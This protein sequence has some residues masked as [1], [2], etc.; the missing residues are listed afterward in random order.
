M[1]ILFAFGF[2]AI[3]A[4]IVGFAIA[5]NVLK[6]LRLSGNK[7]ARLYAILTFI[8]CFAVIVGAVLFG[9][10]FVRLER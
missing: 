6:K 5:H 4:A 1:I 3:V 2:G 8:G 9:L 7:F 10:S